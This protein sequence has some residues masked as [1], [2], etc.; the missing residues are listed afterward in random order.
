MIFQYWETPWL[1]LQ[2]EFITLA[3]VLRDLALNWSV[4]YDTFSFTY[5]MW[6]DLLSFLTQR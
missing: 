5:N 2:I 1:L 4:L 6:T 3:Q